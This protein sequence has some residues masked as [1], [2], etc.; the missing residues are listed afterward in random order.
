MI[1]SP[2][3]FR[4][5]VTRRLSLDLPQVQQDLF[6]M[7]ATSPLDEGDHT[8]NEGRPAAGRRLVPVVARQEPTILLTQRSSDMPDHSGQ[9]AFPGGKIETA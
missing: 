1:D 9:I 5:A 7:G 6:G 8:V 4:L 2:D 3:A